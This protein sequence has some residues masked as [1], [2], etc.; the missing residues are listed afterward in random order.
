M[1]QNNNAKHYKALQS[2]L[3][4][5]QYNKEEKKEGGILCTYDM[6]KF[7]NKEPLCDVMYM[8]TLKERANIDNKC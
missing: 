5:T 2:A 8:Y 7:F 4:S 1:V 6:S 3:N